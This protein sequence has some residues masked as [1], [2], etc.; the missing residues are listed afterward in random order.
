MPHTI[1][2]YI[3]AEVNGFLS[4]L[5]RRVETSGKKAMQQ[6]FALLVA[7]EQLLHPYLQALRVL[8]DEV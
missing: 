1:V 7:I 2:F 6:L 8:Q 3:D 4:I 5:A